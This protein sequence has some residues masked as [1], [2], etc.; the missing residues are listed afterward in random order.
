[1]TK[2]LETLIATAKHQSEIMEYIS[3]FESQDID[4]DDVEL[5]FEVDGF[6]TGCNVSIVEQCA[7]SA[8]TLNALIE[9]LEQKDKR[10]SELESRQLSVKPPED[11]PDDEELL[12]EIELLDDVSM[13]IKTA[14]WLKEL[15][16][17]RSGVGIV[18]GGE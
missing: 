17:R 13:D 10:I 18:T 3:S 12:I 9:E 6:D 7:E 4:G 5:R 14:Q 15:R 8:S 1:M 2:S 11:F 16:R